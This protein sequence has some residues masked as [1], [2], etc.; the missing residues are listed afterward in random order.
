MCGDGPMLLSMILLVGY[1]SP[2]GQSRDM[3]LEVD[4]RNVAY[5]CTHTFIYTNT[6]T[7]TLTCTH[8][9]R[10]IHT[11]AY[12]HTHTYRHIHTHT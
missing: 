5:T 4:V 3:L 1:S 7:Q 10:Y 8:T 6:R 9:N 12:A 2:L 11:Q